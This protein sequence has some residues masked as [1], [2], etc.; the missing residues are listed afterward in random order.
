MTVVDVVVILVISLSA[1]FSLI[2]GFVK[3][4]ISLA[5]W[6]IAI[7]LAA[8]FAPQLAD[9]LPDNIESEAV[10]QAVGFGVLF[11]LSLMVGALVNMLVSQ[12]VKKTGLSGADRIFGVAF[13]IIRGGLIIIVFVVIAGMTPLPEMEWWQSS[14]LLQW[15]ENTAMVL[16]EY[17]PQDLNLSYQPV[18]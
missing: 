8:T 3:E 18:P 9:V 13:G 5:T 16:Q 15:F 7:W 10:R 4:A 1:L 12:V 2:R 11:V 6:I 14:A 17:F